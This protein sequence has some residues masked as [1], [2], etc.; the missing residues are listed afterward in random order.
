MKRVSIKFEY[1]IFVK[2]SAELLAE[3]YTVHGFVNKERKLVR[4][5]Q[6]VY[7]KVKDLIGDEAEEK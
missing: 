1:K 4:V 2:G 5:P 7:Q 3:G 6:E